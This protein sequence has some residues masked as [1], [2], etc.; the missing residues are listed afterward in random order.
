MD[1]KKVT[2]YKDVKIIDLGDSEI[3]ISANIPFENLEPF[4]T[5]ALNNLRKNASAP[6]FRPGKV[7]DN[8]LMEM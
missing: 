7:P 6:G 5:K 1:D 4:K 2:I 3:E 8:I